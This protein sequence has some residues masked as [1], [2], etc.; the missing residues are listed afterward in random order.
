V[1]TDDQMKELSRARFTFVFIL[2]AIFLFLGLALGHTLLRTFDGKATDWVNAVVT[3]GLFVFAYF[4]WNT[5]HDA[6]QLHNRFVRF[7]GAMESHTD[8]LWKLAA[9]QQGIPIVW[10]DP[11]IQKWPIQKKHGAVWQG[12]IMGSYLPEELRGSPDSKPIDLDS[13][14]RQLKS[15][16]KMTRRT[17]PKRNAR[18]GGAK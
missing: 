15:H 5:H 16:T 18:K 17:K 14:F 1:N 11:T 9:R 10:W 13:L 2:C 4:S 12:K 7:V 8:I 6:Q 3:V